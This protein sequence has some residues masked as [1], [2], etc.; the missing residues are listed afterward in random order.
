VTAVTTNV[1]Q[2]T[3]RIRTSSGALSSLGTPVSDSIVGRIY[4]RN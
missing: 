1:R 2:I 4:T 3:V